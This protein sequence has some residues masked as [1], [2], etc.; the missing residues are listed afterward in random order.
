[1]PG[2]SITVTGAG[3][4]AE[5]SGRILIESGHLQGLSVHTGLLTP[6]PNSIWAEV[7]IEL[8]GITLTNRMAILAAGFVGG[9]QVLGWDGNIL[10]DPT[11]Q[12]YLRTWAFNV[13]P[14]YLG[15]LTA[16]PA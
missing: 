16:R 6:A 3:L 13:T 10:L 15:I 14:V 11:M 9:N 1:M 8:G 5:V 2:T 7:G 12:I 4:G